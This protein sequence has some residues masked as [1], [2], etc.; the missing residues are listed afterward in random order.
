M[1]VPG[2]AILPLMLN[3]KKKQNKHLKKKKPTQG[4]AIFPLWITPTAE[5]VMQMVGSQ[6]KLG[7]FYP[8]NPSQ[9]GAKTGVR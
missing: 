2:N 8:T 3:K 4:P 1:A 9:A 6:H 5:K 7:C